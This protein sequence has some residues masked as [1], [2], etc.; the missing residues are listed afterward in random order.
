MKESNLSF[1]GYGDFPKSHVM[2]YLPAIYEQMHQ[3]PFQIMFYLCPLAP[4]VPLVP[5]VPV[6]LLVQLVLETINK[7]WSNAWL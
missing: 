6:I 7:C 3:F 4:A 2:L 1:L 5:L